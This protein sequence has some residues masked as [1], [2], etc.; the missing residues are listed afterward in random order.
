MMSH[1]LRTPLNAIAGYAQLLEMELRGPVTGEQRADLQRIQR[2]GQHLLAVIN[3]ILNFARLEA[4]QLEYSLTTVSL[5]DAIA[6]VS[7][8]LE[9]QMAAKQITYGWRTCD[10][11]LAVRAD[12]DKLRQILLNLLTNATKFTEPGGHISVECVAEPDHAEIRVHDTGCGIPLGAIERIFEPFVQ[13]ERSLTNAVQG[14]GLGLAISRDLA[15]GMKGDLAVESVVGAGSTFTLSLPL[16]T[17]SAD[18]PS[19]PHRCDV[20]PQ[21]SGL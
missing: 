16:A 4:A 13:L 9:P 2:S 1:E 3:N 18:L 10:R 19:L 15:R 7:V 21:M 6:E 12:A 11:E 5:A 8:L 14:T 20:A 17:A